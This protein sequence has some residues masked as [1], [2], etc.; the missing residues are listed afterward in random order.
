MR[1]AA[2]LVGKKIEEVQKRTGVADGERVA[3]M[4]ALMLVHENN[5]ATAAN[6]ASKDDKTNNVNK[7]DKKLIDKMNNDI[8]AALIRTKPL[9]GRLIT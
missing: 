6:T 9:R 3:I 2:T 8:D 7:E 1:H 4:A 5:T